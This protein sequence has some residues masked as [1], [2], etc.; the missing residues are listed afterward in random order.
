MGSGQR[1]VAFLGA[2]T[3]GQRPA[4]PPDSQAAGIADFLPLGV[5]A[6]TDAFSHLIL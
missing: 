5:F 6:N 2:T 1:G 4:Q 3:G